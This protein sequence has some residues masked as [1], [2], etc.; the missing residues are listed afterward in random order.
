M[1]TLST[2][3][4]KRYN[5]H[6]Y[7][8]LFIISLKPM[9]TIAC[10]SQ[11]HRI[12]PDGFCNGTNVNGHSKRR[13][14]VCWNGIFSITLPSPIVLCVANAS[15]YYCAVGSEVKP[16]CILEI[17]MLWIRVFCVNTSTFC[18]HISMCMVTGVS[19][20]IH[21]QLRHTNVKPSNQKPASSN[22]HSIT[23]PKKH[24]LMKISW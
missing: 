3:K 17:R 13:I 24:I 19:D 7:T 8:H 1:K 6:L 14:C 21:Y 10:V 22:H 9:H 18:L 5:D 20:T 11:V 2:D 16:M 23:Q 12:S 15:F 4:R